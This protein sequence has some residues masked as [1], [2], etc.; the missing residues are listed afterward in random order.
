MFHLS[1][2][3]HRLRSRYNLVTRYIREKKTYITISKAWLNPTR[4]RNIVWIIVYLIYIL[5]FKNIVQAGHTFKNNYWAIL[6][7]VNNH[8]KSVHLAR[9]VYT[10]IHGLIWPSLLPQGLIVIRLTK[11]FT[12]FWQPCPVTCLTCIPEPPGH[13]WYLKTPSR[14]GYDMYSCVPW[15]WHLLPNLTASQVSNICLCP[16]I[17]LLPQSFAVS[18]VWRV[19]LVSLNLTAASK[20]HRSVAV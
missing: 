17:W 6:N 2:A 9:E 12:A 14:H 19:Y 20:P 3:K 18:Q 16:W 8:G 15:S 1:E 13:H 5:E 4:L 11:N 7:L 10:C